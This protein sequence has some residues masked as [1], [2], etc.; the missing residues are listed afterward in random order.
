[1][2]FISNP[3]FILMHVNS[4]LKIFHITTNNGEGILIYIFMTQNQKV[5]SIIQGFR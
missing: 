3:T 1:M 2:Y 5:T 4:I